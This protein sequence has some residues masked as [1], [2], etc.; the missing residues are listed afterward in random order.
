M[1][2]YA[3]AQSNF[4]VRIDSIPKSKTQIYS[5]T[6]LFIGEHFKLSKNIIQND[7]ANGGVILIES[8]IN[9]Y[10]GNGLDTKK[11]CYSYNVKFL[12]KDNKCK[13]IINNI[14]YKSGPGLDKSWNISK[15]P[16]GSNLDNGM[17]PGYIE[18]DLDRKD[19]MNLK[20]SIEKELYLLAESYIKYIE[21]TNHNNDF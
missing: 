10:V 13:I 4:I 19:W 14:R 15:L 8:I 16:F 20:I 6:K 3:A 2:N 18:S 7:D 1:A 11:F 17:Y 21:F 9:Q 5:D 12:M